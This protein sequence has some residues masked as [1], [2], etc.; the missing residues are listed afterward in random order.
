MNVNATLGHTER[1]GSLRRWVRVAFLGPVTIVIAASAARADDATTEEFFENR[2][3]PVL[4]GVCLRCHGQEKPKGGLRVDTRD[5]LLKGGKS[6]AAIDKD[7]LDQSLL[8]E[9]IRRSDGVSAM[10]PDK[11]LSPQQVA[12]LTAWVHAG[13]PWPKTTPQIKPASHWAFQPIR[14]VVP[15]AVHDGR[16]MQTSIDRFILARLDAIGR[17]PAPPADRPALLRRLTFGLTGLPPTD[18]ESTAFEQ[19]TSPRAI[20]AVVDRLLASPQYG[21]HWGRHWLDVVRY[22]DTAGETADIPVPL[23]WRYRNYVIDAFNAD[24]PYDVFLREQIAGDILAVEGPRERYAEQATATGYLAIS[25]RFGFDSENYHHLTIQ[26]T[27]DTVGQSVLGLSLGCARCHDHKFDPISMNDYYA[28]YGIF[29][30]SRYA[31]PGSEQKQQVRAMAPLIPPGE[32]QARWRLFDAR[33]DALARGLENQKQPVPKAVL[34]SLHDVDGDFELQAAAAGGSNGVLVQPWLYQGTIAV[35][36]EAQSPYTNLYSR[37]KVGVN[38]PS[39]A[40]PYRITQAIYPQRRPSI[41]KLL[42]VNLDF[43][44]GAPSAGTNGQ[45][46]VWIGAQPNSP[47]VELLISE[48]AVALCSHETIEGLCTLKRN[49]WYNLQLVLD[50]QAQTIS[51][52]VGTADQATAFSGKRFSSAWPGQI[53]LVVLDAVSR[54]ATD[55]R[56]KIVLPAIEFDNFGIQD[57]PIPAVSTAARGADSSAANR[58]DPDK[59]AL[60]VD[61]VAAGEQLNT[62]L[63]NGPFAMTYGMAEGT[64]HDVRVQIRGEPDQP[65]ALVARG[66]IK[67]LGGGPLGADVN[68]SGRLELAQWLIR[69]E[70]P[71]TA[72]VMVNRIWQYHFGRGLVKTPNDFGV[73]G[74]PPSHPDLLDHLAARFIESG[75]SIKA[76]HRLVVSSATYQQ[77]SAGDTTQGDAAGGTSGADSFTPFARRR[78]GAEEIRDAILAK[79]GAL[80]RTLARGHPFPS[81]VGWRFT[82]HAPFNAVYDHDKRSIYLMTQRIKRHPFLALFDG[83]DPNASTA[84]RQTTTVPTQALFFLNDPFVH[85]KAETYA[86]R[87]QAARPDEPGRIEL[88]WRDVL[89]RSPTAAER[90]E[91]LSFLKE[92]RDGLAALKLDHCDLRALAAYVRTLF[93]SNEFV[94]VD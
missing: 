78:L 26:D 38:V 86:T 34:R 13:V 85:A 43:R 12:D 5:A 88:A 22:A 44:V 42:H 68:G 65:G 94:Y 56:T 14:D 75:W 76:M 40:G 81:P 18:E 41:C 82:Q 2:V 57:R 49:Q 21:E 50:L 33:V 45:H 71:L 16:W 59:A 4:A 89:G 3:R 74:L 70:N 9:A 66:L 39:G 69:R 32:S 17:K 23:A 52:S 90:Q 51:G 67:A 7:D 48:H 36:S 73:R 30:S 63:A 61:S 19:D 47:A 20:E 8:L 92:Y 24:K 54:T 72:R 64:P 10:P 11:T 25:R 1:G 46:R 53:D 29:D 6:G 31:F 55:R 93:G 62:L 37:G 83:A 84:V 80:D 35:T 79:S 28:L 27:I 58:T 91:A 87:L 15:P 60:E 77:S